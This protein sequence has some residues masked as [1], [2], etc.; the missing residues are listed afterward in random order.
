M[1][2]ELEEKTEF[3][4]KAESLLKKKFAELYEEYKASLELFGEEPLPF[5]GDDDVVKIFK[6]MKEEF[7]SLPEVL[8]GLNDYAA[9]LCINST[10][11]LLERQGCD[12][13]LA[14]ADDGYVFPSASE[15]GAEE[16]TRNVRAT[17]LKIFR[18]L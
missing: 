11:Q 16:K 14:L 5:P 17:K 7:E 4:N 6:W 2:T 9:S 18:R 1:G 13:F 12:D 10:L 8:A 15:L 3:I